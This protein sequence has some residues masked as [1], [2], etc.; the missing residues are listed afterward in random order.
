MFCATAL[1]VV[2]IGPADLPYDQSCEHIDNYSSH[3]CQK[4]RTWKLPGTTHA[5]S[6]RGSDADDGADA[7]DDGADDGAILNRFVE[8]VVGNTWLVPPG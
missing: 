3:T 4:P 6:S 7:D 2:K 1:L 8:E 5:T